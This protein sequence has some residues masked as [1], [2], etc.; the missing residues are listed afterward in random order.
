MEDNTTFKI[1]ANRTQMWIAR[2]LIATCIILFLLIKII[3]SG[4]ILMTKDG[5]STVY[6]QSLFFSIIP[7]ALGVIIFVAGIVCLMQPGR[8]F[9]FISVVLFALTIV[10]FF[11]AP[12]SFT[13]RLV[14]TPYNFY[15]RTGFWLS[16]T[17]TR[18]DFDSLAYIT[19]AETGKDRHGFPEYELQCFT[20]PEGDLIRIP[21]NDMVEKALSEIIHRASEHGVATDDNIIIP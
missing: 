12:T 14:V 13:H 3:G 5:N 20:K 7:C 11:T 21:V 19:I 17:E 4:E 9:K 1:P 8:F 15:N 6:H 2:V 16:P 10:I 18:V